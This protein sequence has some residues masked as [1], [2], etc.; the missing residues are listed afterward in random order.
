MNDPT[1]TIQQP[2]ASFDGARRRS[3][4]IRSKF[5]ATISGQNEDGEEFQV[6]VV[7]TVVSPG[8]GSFSVAGDE[9]L[10]E[11]LRV[12]QA[13]TVETA[14]GTLDGEINGKWYEPK[15]AAPGEPRRPH[16]GIRLTGGQTWM[17]PDDF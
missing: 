16:I 17:Q 11:R 1:A 9:G 13:V 6:E 12:G 4:R 15:D 3:E 8:G 2:Q 10:F 5:A 14:V 7:S